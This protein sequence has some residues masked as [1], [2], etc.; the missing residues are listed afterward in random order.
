MQI[1]A[2]LLRI[3]LSVEFLDPLIENGDVV[4]A[5]REASLMLSACASAQSKNKFSFS[6][7]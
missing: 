2:I 6:I 4:L 3:C 7:S 5:V 1:M